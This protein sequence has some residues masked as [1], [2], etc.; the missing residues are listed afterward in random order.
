MATGFA[1]V[2]RYLKQE[3]D[4]EGLR[5]ARKPVVGKRRADR[6]EATGVTFSDTFV[7]P[8]LSKCW[9]GLLTF[10]CTAVVVFALLSGFAFWSLGLCGLGQAIRLNLMHVLSPLPPL[11]G[12]VRWCV[13]EETARLPA[14]LSGAMSLIYTVLVFALVAAWWKRSTE[15]AN[16]VA[17]LFSDG[18]RARS[19]YGTCP[20]GTRPE[21][22][23]QVLLMQGPRIG[24]ACLPYLRAVLS[25]PEWQKDPR[26]PDRCRGAIAA[27]AQIFSSS[28]AS[29]WKEKPH[30]SDWLATW[31]LGHLEFLIEQDRASADPTCDYRLA[32]AVVA[33]GRVLSSA[34]TLPERPTE[35]TRGAYH[36]RPRIQHFREQLRLVFSWS[37]SRPALL[38]AG[39]EAAELLGQPEDLEVLDAQT[40]KLDVQA[41]FTTAQTDRILLTRDRVLSRE[42]WSTRLRAAL[43]KRIAELGLE[44]ISDRN[45]AF[46]RPLDGS[47]MALVIAGS[48]CRGDDGDEQYSPQRRVHLG[49]YLIDVS[50]V[51]QAAFRRWR[52]MQGGIMRVERGFFPPQASGTEAFPISAYASNVTWFAAQAYAQWAIAGGHLPTEA[53]WEKAA[54]GCYDDRRYPSGDDWAEPAV[55][56]YGV[57]ACHVVEWTLDA[58]D[59]LAYRHNPSIFDPRIDSSNTDDEALRVIRG[60]DPNT[61]HG[62]YRLVMRHGM[63]PISGALTAPVVFRVVVDLEPGA[64]T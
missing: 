21:P 27:I 3:A 60:R 64:L 62:S 59:R 19:P 17:S 23:E 48:F 49:S 16:Y 52:D 51:S 13:G 24:S 28:A 5:S 10:P 32:E 6:T 56:P 36:D 63:E 50:P 25:G 7:T 47:V 61:P 20:K 22:H 8:L 30:E 53:Q 57:H 38:I 34:Q 18:P 41:G 9:D 4:Y 46:R 55:S 12:A 14:V 1:I 42:P 2:R 26:A 43:L 40:R 54:R 37:A 29:C 35:A 44:P 31:L 33:V 45:D 39:C 11:A 58:F 15:R